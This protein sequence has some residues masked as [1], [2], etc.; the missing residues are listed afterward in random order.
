MVGH[1]PLMPVRHNTAL[2]KNSECCCIWLSDFVKWKAV[3]SIPYTTAYCS[4]SSRVLIIC[5][6]LSL[7]LSFRLFTASIQ[8][9]FPYLTLT[10]SN[11]EN[12]NQKNLNSQNTALLS[13]APPQQQSSRTCTLPKHSH[14]LSRHGL[15]NRAF[16]FSLSLSPSLSFVLLHQQSS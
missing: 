14:P 16:S 4:I 5:L 13:K 10:I 11:H 2:K 15:Q 3:P 12:Q 6:C 1:N 9:T 8:T 7:P